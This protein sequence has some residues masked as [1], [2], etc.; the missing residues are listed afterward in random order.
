MSFLSKILFGNKTVHK[1]S[2]MSGYTAPMLQRTQTAQGVKQVTSNKS[3]R[4][5][6]EYKPDT[7]P[8]NL[9]VYLQDELSSLKNDTV[10]LRIIQVTDELIPHGWN[11]PIFNYDACFIDSRG[12]VLGAKNCSDLAKNGYKIGD[13]VLATRRYQPHSKF[14]YTL[15]IPMRDLKAEA[16]IICLRINDRQ[17]KETSK[18][19]VGV[20]VF[21]NANTQ[22]QDPK[23]GSKAKPHVLLIANN[24]VLCELGANCGEKYS[25]LAS[26]VGV[27]IKKLVVY[28]KISEIYPGTYYYDIEIGTRKSKINPPQ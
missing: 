22:L 26:I 21:T 17:W 23:P 7:I 15:D 16:G 4:D 3:S 14:K 11:Q 28:K 5:I 10:Q 19:R 25:K 18:I 24:Q 12:Y 20:N 27:N 9:T 1:R 2:E 6:V 8:L 13:T